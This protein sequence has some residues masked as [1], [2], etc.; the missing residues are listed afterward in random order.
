MA[1]ITARGKVRMDAFTSPKSSSATTSMPPV[2]PPQTRDITNHRL[3]AS[4]FVDSHLKPYRCKVLACE[5][6]HFSSTA[7]LLRHEREA[8][9]MHGHGDKPF[10]CTYE[11]CERGVP[12]NGF[13]RH[14]NLRDHMKRVHNDPGQ[15]KS[16]ASSSP[17]PSAPMKSKKRKV[18]PERS[19]SPSG[20]KVSKRLAT[21]P[22]AMRQ[23]LQEPSLIERYH[24]S[25]QELVKTVNQLKD[26]KN[27]SNMALLR[28]AGSHIKV[29]ASITHQLNAVPASGEDFIQRSSG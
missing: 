11:G 8:H 5:N 15:P 3:R 21:P 14:W 7:C 12:G 25:K 6:L 26:P 20:D 18:G 23:H 2:H 4:K 1:S 19:E 22:V 16:N 9:A 29:L 10:L 13:P 27:T 24:Q 17:P 28:T